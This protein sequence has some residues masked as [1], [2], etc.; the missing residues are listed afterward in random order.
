MEKKDVH[1]NKDNDINNIRW[2]IFYKPNKCN[3]FQIKNSSKLHI[4]TALTTN[5][6]YPLILTMVV[7]SL[8]YMLD[9]SFD[10]KHW[11]KSEL[12]H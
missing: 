5:E 2:G 4:I 6:F 3:S 7:I 9:I 12:S 10:Y 11:D 8:D 1:R